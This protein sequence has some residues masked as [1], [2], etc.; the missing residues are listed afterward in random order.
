MSSDCE[1]LNICAMKP[2]LQFLDS[3]QSVADPDILQHALSVFGGRVVTS[4]QAELAAP[5]CPPL[6]SVYARKG[7]RGGVLGDGGL[8]PSHISPQEERKRWNVKGY[9][10]GGLLEIHG[11]SPVMTQKGGGKRG[12]IERF[13]EG[14][15]RRLLRQLARTCVDELPIFA[16]LTFPDNFPGNPKAWKRYLDNFFKRLQRVHAHASG[17]WKLELKERQ[18][19]VNVGQKAPHFH[20]L[21]WGVPW[22]WTDKTNGQLRWAWHIQGGS[23]W[24]EDDEGNRSLR[25]GSMFPVRDGMR[26]WTVQ[27]LVEGQRVYFS[28]VGRGEVKEGQTIREFRSE[29]ISGRKCKKIDGKWVETKAG[30]VVVKIETWVVDGVDHIK[31]DIERLKAKG[32]FKVACGEVQLREWLSMTW[33]AV[34][35]SDDPRHLLAGT[36]VEQTHSRNQVMYYASKYVCKSDTEGVEDQGRFWGIFNRESIP[37]SQV[38][39]M[40]VTDEQAARLVRVARRYVEASYRARGK[41]HHKLKIRRGCGTTIF[42]DSAWWLAN[43]GRLWGGG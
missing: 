6:R 16:T 2:E 31:E 32:C 26:L 41:F 36:N 43:C 34:V 28:D 20:L 19:G 24:E 14:S 23:T 39:D 35:G 11:P 15:R 40:P 13:S 12:N 33:A 5:R 38:V 9:P 22:T 27:K 42:C 4:E 18:S 3:P 29:Y 10:Q 30:H 21:L 7:G 37:W 25:K 17:F 8:S 1:E